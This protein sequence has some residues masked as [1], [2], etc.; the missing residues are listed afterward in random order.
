V[1]GAD[2]SQSFLGNVEISADSPYIVTQD[3]EFR[4][5]QN[6]ARSFVEKAH[7][8]REASWNNPTIQ[9]GSFKKPNFSHTTRNEKAAATNQ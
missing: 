6:S 3:F 9:A 2:T 5:H 4:V 8:R 1:E 7:E